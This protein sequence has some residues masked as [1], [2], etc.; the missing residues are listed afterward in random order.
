V[1]KLAASGITVRV[2]SSDLEEL[3]GVADRIVCVRA[4]EIVADRPSAEFDK[5]SLL[6]AVS[7]AP[8]PSTGPC[9]Y[10]GTGAGFALASCA[11]GISRPW[12]RAA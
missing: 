9:L 8:R 1:R 4:G 3:L 11:A 2:T 7:T 10:R 12:H 5:I 6:A